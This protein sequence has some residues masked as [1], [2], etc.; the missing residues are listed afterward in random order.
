MRATVYTD[1]LPLPP[2]EGWGE[3]KPY[4]AVLC[5]R[6]PSPTPTGGGEPSPPQLRASA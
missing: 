3:G 4:N 2:G 5:P 1:Q 6:T